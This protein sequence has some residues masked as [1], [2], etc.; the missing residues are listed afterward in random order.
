MSI[1]KPNVKNTNITPYFQEDR[2]ERLVVTSCQGNYIEL[3][4]WGRC[5]DINAGYWY[6]IVGYNNLEIQAAK[7]E[8]RGESH[9]WEGFVHPEAEKLAAALVDRTDFSQICYAFS[10]SVANDNAVKAAF[11]YHR[12]HGRDNRDLIVSLQGGY[13]GDTELL[14]HLAGY[15]YAHFFPRRELSRKIKPPHKS[16]SD[17]EVVEKANEL[18]AVIKAERLEERVAAFIY[19]PVM[20]VRGALPLPKVYLQ[21]IQEICREH[22]ILLIADEVATGFGRTGEL[23]AHRL[24]GIKP[25]IMAIGKAFTNGDYPLS[26]TLFN[27]KVVEALQELQCQHPQQVVYLFGNTLAG[28]PEGCAVAQKVLKII[29]RDNYLIQV[30]QKGNYTLERLASLQSLPTVRD[31]RG[32]G[33]MLAVE[34]Q[35]SRLAD[36]VQL[37]MRKRQIHLIPEG[38]MIMIMP[39]FTITKEEIDYAAHCLEEILTA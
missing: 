13:H 37:E 19:E 35:D 11:F 28:L 25:D 15:D 18:E 36:S 29:E 2:G 34:V 7:A 17:E 22:D 26:A 39:P 9:L 16:K 6:K 27:N 14:C 31:V 30:R 10:G 32:T 3:E 8:V 21:R 33:L 23:F 20:G 24:T 5:L 1:E 4:G 38:R 12:A